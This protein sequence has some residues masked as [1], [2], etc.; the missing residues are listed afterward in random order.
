VLDYV[1]EGWGGEGAKLLGL[2]IY[3]AAFKLANGE[4]WQAVFLKAAAYWIYWDWV[5]PDG[6]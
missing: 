5:Q 2:Q 4:K 6:V 1:P 3:E